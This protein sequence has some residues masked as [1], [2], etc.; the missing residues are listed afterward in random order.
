M[1]IADLLRPAGV[2]PVI[3]IEREDQAV[4]LA[5]AL[6]AGGLSVLEVTFRT[7]AAAGAIAAIRRDVPEAVVGAGTLLTV[8]QVRAAK[9]AGAAFGV[10]PGFDPVIVDEAKSQLLPFCP[11]VATASEVSQALTAGCSTLKFFPAEA[12]GGV[13]M[14][15]NLLGA[16][17]SAGVRFMPTGGVSA[18]N[19]AD[20]LS[21]PEVISCGGTWIVP[22]AS[23]AAGD[24][25]TIEKLAS[26]AA[27]IARRVRCA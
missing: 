12:A 20:Y 27:S 23:L 7:A 22:K 5:R 14:I 8:E 25:A 9:R 16:F 2:V 17:R 1:D 18:G 19:L 10:A 15:K 6:A 3:V 21:V 26:E 11:G 4:P 24:Y 13:K